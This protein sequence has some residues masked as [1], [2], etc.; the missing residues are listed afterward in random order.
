[1]KK[2]V[3]IFFVCFLGMHANAQP[4]QNFQVSVLVSPNP[5]VSDVSI[6]VLN[7]PEDLKITLYDMTGKLVCDQLYSSSSNQLDPGVPGIYLLEV[8]SQS[9]K[10]KKIVRIVKN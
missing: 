2:L 1:M 4:A 9:K 7:Q 8:S 6:I 10:F 5:T 3:L